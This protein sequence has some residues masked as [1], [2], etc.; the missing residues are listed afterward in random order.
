MSN[1]TCP[2]CGSVYPLAAVQKFDHFACAMCHQTIVVPIAGPA[3]SR[4]A[5]P[6]QTRAPVPAPPP[7]PSEPPP[8]PMRASPPRPAP[9]RHAP[10][11]RAAPHRAPRHHAAPRHREAAPSGI[12]W[13]VIGA[14]VAVLAA[15]IVGVLLF[16]D[17]PPERAVVPAGTPKPV[18]AAPAAPKSNPEKDPEAWKALS[19]DERAARTLNYLVALD[20][21]DGQRLSSAFSFMRE[22]NETEAMRKIAEMELARDPS[23][24]WAHQARGDAMV[25]ERVE[26]CLAECPRAD[27]ADSPGVQKIARL[28]K[29]HPPEKGAWWADPA[30]QKELDAAI[31]QVRT[32]EKLL[33]DPFEWAVAKWTIY[34]KRIEVMKDHPAITGTSG[35]YLIFVQVKAAAGTPIESV[36]EVEIN[37]AQRVLNQNK[38]LFAEF[39]DGFHDAFGKPFGLVK[40]EKPHLDEKTILK[41]NIF[42]DE[43]TWELYHQRMGFLPFMQGIRA[44]YENEEP[45]FIVSYDP[46]GQEL[47]SETDQVQCHEATHQLL[48]FYTW[49]V[50]RKSEGRELAWAECD[51]R[52]LWLDAGFAEF[53]SS[54]RREGGKYLWTQP[55][56]NRMESLWVFG[57]VFQK[58]RWAMWSLDEMLAIVD[59]RQ[60]ADQATR[61]VFPKPVKQP[62]EKQLADAALAVDLFRPVF[63]AKSWSLVFFMWNQTDA[64]GRPAYRDRFAAFMKESFRVKQTNVEGR[65][66]KTHQI[67]ASDFRK[68]MGLESEERF[69]AFEKEWLAWE[70][71]YVAKAQTNAW[72]ASRDA[73]FQRL[74]LTK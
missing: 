11:P 13:G 33:A 20:R 68:S 40:L 26:R 1:L 5:A 48:H 63:Y 30:E 2:G 52:P 71:A 53:F 72:L 57:Q 69:R 25:L 22:R 59:Q 18:V 64:S 28:R 7:P 73:W 66:L 39:Y 44:Y 29:A 43:T 38:R 61:R 42:A 23:T 31:S 21:R 62:T 45:R 27:E 51:T 47:S 6:M 41:A 15:T 60:V 16:T 55:L 58:M 32:E 46:G 8:I 54:H 14:G 50:T 35:P 65:G 56:A 49:D 17:K 9:V 70:T 12:N 36:P 4:A 19:S 74:R 10:P 24:G 3:A 67:T 34:Q 37:R